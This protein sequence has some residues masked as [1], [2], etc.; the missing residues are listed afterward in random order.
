M[1]SKP[2]KK[3]MKDLRGWVVIHYSSTNSM[4]LYHPKSNARTAMFSGFSY[5]VRGLSGLTWDELVDYCQRFKQNSDDMYMMP[6]EF[7]M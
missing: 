3:K 5:D 2:K 6:A 1:V 4:F 7:L